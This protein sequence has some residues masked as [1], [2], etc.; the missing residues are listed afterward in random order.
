MSCAWR[1]GCDGHGTESAEWIW[2]A[3][4]RRSA[5]T[6]RDWSRVLRGS[7]GGPPAPWPSSLRPSGQ[8]R[9]EAG[10]PHRGTGRG[11]PISAFTALQALRDIA[12]VQPGQTVLVTGASGGVGT[13][14]VQIA[15]AFGAAV[16]G[17]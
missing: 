12:K 13:F 10:H 3:G 16:T 17:V 6:C 2:P 1:S 9:P 11:D 8:F 5:G 14:A 4:S 15:K 7:A